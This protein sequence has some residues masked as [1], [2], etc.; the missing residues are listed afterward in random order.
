MH[1]EGDSV[2]VT[3]FRSGKKDS[4]SAKLVK[5]TSDE[6]SFGEEMMPGQWG[7]MNMKL[8]GLNDSFGAEQRKMVNIEIQQAMEQAHKAIQDAMRQMPP[9]PDTQRKLEVIKKKL[10]ALGE[11]GVNVGKDATVVVKN[12]GP[13]SVRTVVKSDD[14]GSY[15]ILADPHKHLTVHDP[16]GKLVFDGPI[17]TKTDQEKVPRKVWKKVEPMLNDLA[18]QSTPTAAPEA[19][20]DS[21]D[22]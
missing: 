18:R 16:D 14:T 9:N 4:V 11:G 2:K 17:E 13:D 3:F 19:K 10:G 21:S 7:G 22:D 5:K 20:S 8:Q 15:V 12:E 6:M 1:A